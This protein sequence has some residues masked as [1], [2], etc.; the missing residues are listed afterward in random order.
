MLNSKIEFVLN[1]K[2][3]S[4]KD[5]DT[6]TTVL[7]FLRN[8]KNLTVGL[9]PITSAFGLSTHVSNNNQNPIS[10][11]GVSTFIS[12]YKKDIWKT[13]YSFLFEEI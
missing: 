1:D 12:L 6:N 10:K 11:K 7:N 9:E 8:E 5:L 3:V 4:I 2:L 13:S